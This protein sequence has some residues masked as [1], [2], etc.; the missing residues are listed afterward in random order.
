MKLQLRFWSL[1]ILLLCSAL[2]TCC[3]KEEE[4][5]PEPGLV[6]FVGTYTRL[7]TNTQYQGYEQI[8]VTKNSELKKYTITLTYQGQQRK[9]SAAW[10]YFEGGEHLTCDT[11]STSNSNLRFVT[12]EK[13]LDAA[14]FLVHLQTCCS[15]GTVLQD[16]YSKD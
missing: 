10:K 2:F 7:F 15:F 3:H 8:I 11:G 16:T 14:N 6:S 5:S 1:S 12:I 4:P 9:Y 13:R